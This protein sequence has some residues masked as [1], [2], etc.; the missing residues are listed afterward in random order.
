MR[1]RFE[2]VLIQVG[3]KEVA[4]ASRNAIEFLV[5]RLVVA[6][7]E[8]RVYKV[9]GCV[10]DDYDTIQMFDQAVKEGLEQVHA[11]YR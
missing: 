3:T 2:L 5:S 9:L 7:Q 4:A 8:V 11:V 10:V 1:F 6:V